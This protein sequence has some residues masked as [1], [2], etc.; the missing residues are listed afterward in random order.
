MGIRMGA[1][2]NPALYKG[3]LDALMRIAREEGVAGLYRW[4]CGVREGLRGCL[5]V[6]CA[7][8]Y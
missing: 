8:S 2:N 1:T 3:T 5:A 7:G 4:V 6:T